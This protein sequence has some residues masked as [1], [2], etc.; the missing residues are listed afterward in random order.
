MVDTDGRS[1]LIT[2]LK[3]APSELVLEVVKRA[4]VTD[5]AMLGRA[6]SAC[7]T[8]VRDSGLPWAGAIQFPTCKLCVSSFVYT[9]TLLEWARAH[10]Y[11]WNEQTSALIAEKAHM[12][13]LQWAKLNGCPWGPWTCAILAKAGRL[14]DLKWAKSNG[15][16]MDETTCSSA[17]A[18]GH[19]HV[20]KWA[21]RVRCPWDEDTCSSAAKGG[22]LQVL[23][24]ARKEGCP[25]TAWT[26]ACAAG[27]GHM[28]VYRWAVRTGCP[29]K[30]TLASESE[31]EN[32]SDH[33]RLHHV[34]LT[35]R[36]GRGKYIEY[37][38]V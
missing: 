38:I 32:E 16:E 31:E 34:I 30:Y 18:G 2:F 22:H 29:V 4:N 21:K 7:R 26:T 20:L 25:W 19:L 9:I 1:E 5:R 11:V 17:A 8:A 27:A 24:W 37:E 12:G 23:Q 14:V 15:C 13:V 28:E 3:N 36:A 35:L 33:P 6:S 10:G